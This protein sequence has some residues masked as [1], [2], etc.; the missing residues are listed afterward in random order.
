MK[1]IQDSTI[2]RSNDG[3][4]EIGFVTTIHHPRGGYGNEVSASL[5][6]HKSESEH[7]N[8]IKSGIRYRIVPEVT[9]QEM[10]LKMTLHDTEASCVSANKKTI[11]D[12]VL[13]MVTKITQD[14]VEKHDKPGKHIWRGL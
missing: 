14:S 7:V 1:R 8:D 3:K 12:K 13:K 2:N 6:A 4:E 9:V 10:I 11:S 5:F